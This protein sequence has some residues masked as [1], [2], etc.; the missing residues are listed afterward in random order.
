MGK[1]AGR[2]SAVF[3]NKKQQVLTISIK[4]IFKNT[5][6]MYSVVGDIVQRVKFEEGMIVDFS[7]VN[8]MGFFTNCK[9]NGEPC[10]YSG[11]ILLFGLK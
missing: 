5:E 11:K 9:I 4:D 7:P 1:I 2:I 8:V 6:N 3:L 10:G